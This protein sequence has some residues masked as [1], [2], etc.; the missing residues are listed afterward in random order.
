MVMTEETSGSGNQLGR[1]LTWKG[2]KRI[3]WNIG[4]IVYTYKDTLSIHKIKALTE[5]TALLENLNILW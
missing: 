2:H 1:V 3:F 5:P 4:S